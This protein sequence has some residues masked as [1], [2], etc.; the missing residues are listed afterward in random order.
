MST[1]EELTGPVMDGATDATT[2]AKTAGLAQ[3]AQHDHPDNAAALIKD[4]QIRTAETGIINTNTR[5][6]AT[7]PK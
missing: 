1:D 6:N 3:Q 7:E 5:A 2:A 4:L